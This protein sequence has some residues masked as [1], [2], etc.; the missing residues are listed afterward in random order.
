MKLKVIVG[1]SLALIGFQAQAATYAVKASGGGNY[2]TIQAC[3]TVAVAGDTCVVY[4]GT[5][6]ETVSPAHSGT[7]GNPITFSVNPGDCVAVTGF[8][9][10]TRNYVTIGT[11]GSAYCTNG[12]Y[13]YSGFELLG[14]TSWTLINNVIFQNNYAHSSAGPCFK[15]PSG[16]GS[17]SSSYDYFLNNIVTACGGLG[18]TLTAG[19]QIEGD[20]WL[21][22]G[23]TFSHLQSAIQIYCSYC[24]VRNNHFGPLAASDLTTQHSQPIESSCAGDFP[25]VHM[26]YENN[27]LQE[28][29]GANSHGFLLRDTEKCGQTANIIRLSTHID[30]G[31]YFA[32]LSDSSTNEHIY[33]MSISNTQLDVGT[34]DL[35]DISFYTASTG[36]V[37]INNLITNTTQVGSSGY[38]VAVGSDSI[39]GFVE[40]HNLCFN[41]G[42]TGPWQQPYSGYTY[43]TTDIF[44]HDP[45]FIGATTDLRLQPNSGAIGTG[46]PLTTAVGAGSG[47]TTLTVAD[48]GFFSYGFGITNVQPDWIRI[49]SSTTVQI[50]SINYATNVITLASAVSWNNGDPVYLY[51][52]SMG[53]VVLTGAAPNI[54]A[55]QGPAT[56]VQQSPVVR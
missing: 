11:P 19:L 45:V 20:H 50:S 15:A 21:V 42:W 47:S 13:T 17:G 26:L 51:K 3:A 32:V 24:V 52:N 14:Q 35:E 48:A 49:G 37:V 25:L 2:T 29:R 56:P 8:S 22:D 10:G 53:A 4:A 5:Y 38:C 44:N 7:A 27:V 34:K 28:W 46:G 23:N 12:S 30:S 39:T 6:N 43:A 18:A 36:G 9:L 33:N 55:S 41:T 31:S 54:G 40:H 1:L 16:T